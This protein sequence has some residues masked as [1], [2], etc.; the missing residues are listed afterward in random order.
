MIYS[1]KTG[2]L[3][4]LKL[5]KEFFQ[6]IQYEFLNLTIRKPQLGIEIKE[7]DHIILREF[8]EKTNRYTTNIC[9][10]SIFSIVM[11]RF[12]KMNKVQR[13]QLKIVY[14]IEFELNDL[15]QAIYYKPIFLEQN[16]ESP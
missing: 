7:N 10:G 8:N 6:K 9:I 13:E 2:R 12:D 11:I 16:Y 15:F 4:S 5:N 3:V 1:E 14:G